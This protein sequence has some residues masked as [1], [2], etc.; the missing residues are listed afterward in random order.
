MKDSFPLHAHVS[1][2]LSLP[3]QTEDDAY[4]HLQ[5]RRVNEPGNYVVY[6]LLK[7]ST[8]TGKRTLGKCLEGAYKGEVK[9]KLIFHGSGEP[10]HVT[11]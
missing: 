8:R 10:S 9:G 1:L 5:M 11:V 2:D 3:N 6:P 4:V 7:D